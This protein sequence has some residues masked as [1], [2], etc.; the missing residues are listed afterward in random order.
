MI[1]PSRRQRHR[2]RGVALVTTLMI[3]VLVT[4]VALG[5]FNLARMERSASASHFNR[6]QAAEFARM[7]GESVAAAILKA[8]ASTDHTWLSTPGLLYRG[9][10]PIDPKGANSFASEEVSLSSGFP[11]E[12]SPAIEYLAPA[13]LNVARF[14]D[15]ARRLIT[16]ENA[17]A[18]GALSMPLKWI[19]VR[20]D[21]S[22]DFSETPDTKNAANPI[23]GRYAYWADDES[24]KLNLN[25]AWTR[26]RS[27]NPARQGSPTLVNLTA[28]GGMTPAIA[29]DIHNIVTTDSYKTPAQFFNSPEDYSRLEAD[30]FNVLLDKRFSVTHFNHD[31]DTT[32]FNEPR[33]VLTTKFAVANPGLAAEGFTGAEPDIDRNPRYRPY[34]RIL[35]KENTDPGDYGNIDAAKLNSTMALLKSYLERTDWPFLAG[36]SFQD[37]YYP[38]ARYPDA[39]QSS[40]RLAQLA[41]HII[42]YVRSKEAEASST[43]QNIIQ[44][45]RGTINPTTGRFTLGT[46]A[47]ANTIVGLARAPVITEMGIWL[48]DDMREMKIFTE[49]YL[50]P[51][52]GLSNITLAPDK[53]G[54]QT[55]YYH[56]GKEEAE[57]KRLRVEELSPEPVLKPGG[58]VVITRTRSRREDEDPFFATRPTSL[59][60]RSLLN[61]ATGGQTV[62]FAPIMRHGMPEVPIAPEG[63]PESAIRT[64]EVDDPRV[65]KH[66]DDWAPSGDPA[67]NSLGRQ[68]SRW[69]VGQP[70]NAAFVPPQ[71]TDANGNVSDYSL[72]M[73]PPKGSPGNR[74]GVVESIGEI[75]YIHTGVEGAARAGVPWRTFRLQQSNS[76]KVLP[77]W[78]LMDLFTVP[79]EAPDASARQV[80]TP[81]DRMVGG[82]VNLNGANIAPFPDSSRVDPLVGVFLGVTKNGTPLK[83]S[84]AQSIAE[85]IRNHNTRVSFPASGTTPQLYHSPGA[86][87]EVNGVADTGEASEDIVRQVA[88]QLTTRGNVFSVYA[89]GQSLRQT[90]DGRLVM[91]AEQR[92]QSFV[93]RVMN[94]DGTLFT[95]KIYQRK[96][97]P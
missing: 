46:P 9:V 89:I 11:D 60:V 82:R 47:D 87:I 12:L 30:A 5:V 50:P 76:G 28:L 27:L 6:M 64:I 84:Q 45:L 55:S 14:N 73:P 78:A 23:V 37:K 24:S 72:R 71:D 31:P 29:R 53:L 25:L 93:E 83:L 95:R 70:A 51:D 65:N 90:P 94:S 32:F 38:A 36:A 68:N 4:I 8:T 79:S 80:L 41:L 1:H 3:L 18:S 88:N 42:D 19:Y 59:G 52:Y 85:K 56:D 67:G 57:S 26:D 2:C 58:Y 20:K 17:L 40:G 69:S 43:W 77:D 10:D 34:L 13:N 96:L 33:I 86:V 97:N 66:K 39:A 15:P 35:K 48:S 54:N 75:G 81:H 91:L 74:Y 44:P 21:G 22:R 49:L 92:T 61:R 62:D 63:T 16:D 7:G